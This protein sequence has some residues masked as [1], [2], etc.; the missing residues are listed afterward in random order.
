MCPVFPSLLPLPLITLRQTTRSIL[1]TVFLDAATSAPLFS[2][3]TS[4]GRTTVY[5]Y[6]HHRRTGSG[7][8]LRVAEVASVEWPWMS[9]GAKK[10][11]PTVTLLGEVQSA[12]QFL[13]KSTFGGYVPSLL[14]ECI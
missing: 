12:S 9:S 8:Q 10:A 4:G 11:P 3:E 1:D 5:M 14:V 13:K 2:V 6:D 7:A